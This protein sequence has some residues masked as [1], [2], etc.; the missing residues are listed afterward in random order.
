MALGLFLLLAAVGHRY[1]W[2]RD[3]LYL[4]EAGMHPDL[5]YPDQPAPVPLLAAWWYQV[6]DG[7]LW[8]FR[9][10]PAAA[11]AVVVLVAGAVSRELGGDRDDQRWTA[12]LV[13]T[14]TTLFVTGHLF[15]TTVFDLV[16]TTS[17]VLLL[18]RVVGRL[19]TGTDRLGNWLAVGATTGLAL[20]VKTLPILVV[21]CCLM[22]LLVVGPRTVWRRPAAYVAAGLAGAGLVPTLVWQSRNGWPQ[23]TMAGSIADGGSGTSSE[24]WLMPLMLPTLTGA[25]FV[26]VVI[27]AVALWR[28]LPV[29]WLPMAAVMLVVVLVLAG[30]KPYYAFGLVPVL[31][32]A[33]VR[34]LRRWRSGRLDG[35][36]LLCALVV[37][38][39]IGGAFV[40]LPL[41]PA[42]QAPVAIVYDHGEQVGWREVVDEVAEAASA[43]DADLVLTEN[44]GQAGALDQARREGRHL[45]PVISGHTGYWWWSRPDGEPQT[46]VA[47]GWTDDRLLDDWFQ[48]CRQVSALANDEGVDNDEAGELVRVCTSPTRPW[49]ELWP[50]MRRS[51]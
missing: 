47:V 49:A 18:V 39:A 46:A 41:L 50:L 27:G 22:A 37:V 38:N 29:R 16:L 25:T 36:S 48:D 19:T 42:A 34:A 26:V 7:H 14:A 21:G 45:P 28:S 2:H 23:L 51:G 20:T 33:G 44:Y 5:S 43:A 4:V 3:E 30:G 13:A 12:L 9:L 10:L 40:G 32:A 15:G 35:R 31:A 11:A 1:G 8:L 6:V 24:R 17:A